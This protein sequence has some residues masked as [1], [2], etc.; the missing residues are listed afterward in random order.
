MV[1]DIG[2][3]DDFDD[4]DDGGGNAFLC[5]RQLERITLL[6]T[7]MMVMM[8]MKKNIFFCPQE[9]FIQCVFFTLAAPCW[10]GPVKK[11]R[12]VG[13]TG[14]KGSPLSELATGV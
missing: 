7:V 12:R 11:H 3:C 1:N 2:H 8:T 5:D 13:S 14:S 10:A 6:S 4:D 9:F